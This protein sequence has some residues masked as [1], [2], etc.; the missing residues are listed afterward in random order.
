MG[1]F[2]TII[3]VVHTAAGLYLKS[4][5]GEEESEIQGSSAQIVTNIGALK[6][7]KNL[8]DGKTYIQNDESKDYYIYFSRISDNQ[9]QQLECNMTLIHAHSKTDYTD[10][11]SKYCDGYITYNPV[12]SLDDKEKS[13]VTFT[14]EYILASET[15]FYSSEDHKISYTLAMSQ[16]EKQLN[17]TSQQAFEKFTISFTDV[18]GCK[19]NMEDNFIDKIAEYYL[20]R[21]DFPQ[22][23]NKQFPYKD[24]TITITLPKKHKESLRKSLLA[25]AV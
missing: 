21:V 15:T 8:E 24:V 18:K 20:A 2:N 10:L 3:K 9:K 23:C 5:S 11:M 16:D 13:V 25:A 14:A 4:T 19:F 7:I 6:F 12:D 17:F 22:G 1:W